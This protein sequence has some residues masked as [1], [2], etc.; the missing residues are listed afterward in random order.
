M[1][2]RYLFQLI[3]GRKPRRRAARKWNARKPARSPKYRA[4]IRSLPSAVSG[5]MGCQH[6]HTGP[7]GIG[8]KA[9]DYTGIP[10]TPTE[11]VQLHALG[12]AQFEALHGFSIEALVS[13]LNQE[14]FRHNPGRAA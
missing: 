3:H 2:S 5:A 9:S 7:H 13:F 8:I 12:Q 4:W 10:L 11:H 14:W 1:N 6:C